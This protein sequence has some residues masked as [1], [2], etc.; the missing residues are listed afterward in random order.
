[1]R[2]QNLCC[3]SSRTHKQEKEKR[4]A[5]E[6]FIPNLS[7]WKARVIPN[8]LRRVL[9]ECH[10][11]QLLHFSTLSAKGNQGCTYRASLI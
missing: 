11:P 4:P 8:H 9:L 5:A 10:W 6:P 2:P 1:M 7:F 3:F